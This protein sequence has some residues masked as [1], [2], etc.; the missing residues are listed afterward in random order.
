[1]TN[2]THKPVLLQEST[3]SLKINPSGIYIDGTFGR[4]GHSLE[5]LKQLST[6]GRLFAFDCDADSILYAENNISKN[7]FIAVHSPFSLIKKYCDKNNLTG[8]INGMLFDLGVSSPQL[9]LAHRGFSFLKDGPLD[10]RMDKRNKMTA[11][12]VLRLLSV[13][14]IANIFWKYGQERYAWTIAKAIKRQIN[15][16]KRIDTTK[17]LANLICELIGKKEKKH[18]A[19]RCFQALRIYVNQEIAELEKILNQISGLLAIKGRLSIISFH[20][21]EHSLIKN[22]IRDAVAGSSVN[23]RRDLPIIELHQPTMKWIIKKCIPSQEE[24][25]CNFRA[26]SAVLRTAEKI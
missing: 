16:G 25:G 26:R 4:G 23:T 24:I 7:N 10:M 13:Q 12:K 1:M 14:K 20:S 22:F 19:T 6:K 18:P 3:C 11:S 17:Q 21:L 2:N 5:I 9:N 8:K 15:S